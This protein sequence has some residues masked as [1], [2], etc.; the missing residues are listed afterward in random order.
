MIGQARA[1]FSRLGE[2]QHTYLRLDDLLL[3]RHRSRVCPLQ[4]GRGHREPRGTTVRLRPSFQGRKAPYQRASLATSGC[5][6]SV[7][8][9]NRWVAFDRCDCSPLALDINALL[10]VVSGLSQGL[11]QHSVRLFTASAPPRWSPLEGRS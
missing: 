10:V 7:R 5:E 11:Q 8:P 1:T 4:G 6:T 9:N 2:L 3:G